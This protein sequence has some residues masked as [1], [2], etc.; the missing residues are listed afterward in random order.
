MRGVRN[1]ADGIRVVE[2]ADVPASGVRVAVASSGI[3]G[4]DLHMTSFGPSSVTLGHE[5]CGRLDDGTPVAVLPAVRCGRCA[6]CLAGEAQQ[7][8]EVFG[9]MYGT[10]LDGGLA[11][12]V[13]V[14]PSCATPLPPTLG[15]DVACLVEP[16]AVAL[17]GAHRSGVTRD[18]NVLVIG[19]G[20]IGL[21]AVA[22][23]RGL[24]ATV[25]VRGHRPERLA[26]AERLGAGRAFELGL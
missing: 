26:A 15:L 7:C 10:S 19:V 20:P 16:V 3:C 9:S 8:T 1:T 21:C 11:D 18:S 6:R 4:S 14:D 25:D 13:W 2:L 5:F 22:V 23:V 17:H 24:G 12:Q